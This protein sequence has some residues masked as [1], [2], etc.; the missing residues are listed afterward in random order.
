MDPSQQSCLIRSFASNVQ[1][2]EGCFPL[3]RFDAGAVAGQQ[4]TALSLNV[5]SNSEVGF[6]IGKQLE[7]L[8]CHGFAA[9][10]RLTPAYWAMRGYQNILVRN[11]GSA[12]TY[13]SVAV[14]LGYAAGFFGLAVW[15]F[16]RQES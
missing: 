10:G 7:V 4:P 16:K 2:S 15:V 3:T 1:F 9:V 12:S 5:V 8:S 11:L 14:L 13:P 6:S